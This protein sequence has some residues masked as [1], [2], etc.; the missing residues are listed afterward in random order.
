MVGG[1]ALSDVLPSTG[2]TKV[3]SLETVE[4]LLSDPPQTPVTHWRILGPGFVGG[5]KIRMLKFCPHLSPST[6]LQSGEGCVE[7][8][9][10]ST[11]V[12]MSCVLG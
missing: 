2:P 5:Q 7:A 1:N 12:V 9:I 10:R 3:R 11:L 8:A 6:P 4:Q